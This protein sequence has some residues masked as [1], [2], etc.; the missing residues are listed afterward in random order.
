MDDD[1]TFD[2]SDIV[3][4]DPGPGDNNLTT[5]YAKKP[6]GPSGKRFILVL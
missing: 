5:V 2:A 4:D 6:D 3:Y 1:N